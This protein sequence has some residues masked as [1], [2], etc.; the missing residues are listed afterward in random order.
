M[1]IKIIITYFN[2]FKINKKALI[3]SL[4]LNKIILKLL[5]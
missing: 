2:S 4:D 5:K 1:K 3:K